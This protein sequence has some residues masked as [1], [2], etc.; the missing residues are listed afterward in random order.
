ML[1]LLCSL[2]LLA[3]QAAL[4]QHPQ[5]QCPQGQSDHYCQ[6]FTDSAAGL[7]LLA[8]PE[9]ATG[10]PNGT[11]N[12]NLTRQ[13]LGY[14][15]GRIGGKVLSID[16]DALKSFDSNDFFY[17]ALVRPFANSTTDR[18]TFFLTMQVAGQ[19][20][21]Y[22]AGFKVSTSIYSS[23]LELTTLQ[24]N[25][26]E[27]LQQAPA[28]IVLGAQDDIDGQWYLLRVERRQGNLKLFLNSQLMLTDDTIGNADIEQLGIWS[29]NRSFEL[30]YLRVGKSAIT[31][32]YINLQQA[33]NQPLTGYQYEQSAQIEWQVTGADDSDIELVNLTPQRVALRQQP[34]KFTVDYLQPGSA[35]VLLRSKSQPHIFKQLHISVLPALS[36][37][38]K[39]DQ[40]VLTDI[41]PAVNTTVPA[42]T[43]LRVN[44][45]RLFN[46]GGSG[47]VRIYQLLTDNNR[48]L[49]DEIRVKAETDTFGSISAN[50]LRSINRDMLWRDG[51][52]LVIKPH[53]HALQS[54]TRYQVVI[55]A[56]TVNFIDS[57]TQFAGIGIDANW[58]FSTTAVPVAR[59]VMQVAADGA[60]DFNTVQGALNF[61]MNA[62]DGAA[63]ETIRLAAGIYHEPLY[64]FATKNLTIEG[65]GAELS[66]IQFTNYD[67]LNS[68]L[69]RGVDL[70]AGHTAGG[71][72]L[73]LIEDVG[74]LTLKQLRFTNL[75]QRKQGVRNQAETVY[76]N[77]SGKLLAVNSHFISEQ[78]TLMLKGSSYF[79]R[80]LIAGNVDFIWGQNYLSLFEQNEIRSVGNSVKQ[81]DAE[82]VDGSYI[83]QA[84]TISADAPGFIFIN[85]R[86][87]S[88]PGPTGNRIRPGSTFLARSAGRP[89]YFD[90]V[91]LLNNQLGPHIAP[92][93]WAG[94]ANNEPVANPAI[95]N[96]NSGWREFG[97]ADFQGKPLDL[98]KRQ[99][100]IEL[101]AEQ[102]PYQD[103]K[104]VLQ[105][106]WPDFNPEWLY[107]KQSQ[108]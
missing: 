63:V 18:H 106:H 78:D 4:P 97:S 51:T 93:G 46:I 55:A 68:G 36:F 50:K 81:P 70:V 108:N 105:Q 17:E 45:K 88:Y 25:Q 61:V 42:D 94:P 53:S 76:F 15:A 100:G 44:L 107:S 40:A 1:L 52:T 83:L 16:T 26:V 31:T 102:L 84:R 8:T 24:N 66:H 33:E 35:S 43:L 101:S 38:A 59:P 21:H 37:P 14:K 13:T 11:L 27:V 87:T 12:L 80:C 49:V 10:Q 71:R 41:H 32:P 23:G 22:A 74:Q 69:G 7:S 99:Y 95:P 48:V 96:T 5:Y 75:H 29:F 103:S 86:F 2:P 60:A 39:T 77:S 30:D 28:P 90:Q 9:A 92:Q 98:S 47:A 34:G 72:S 91:L 58:S 3:Q 57:N 73:F 6:S 85:N 62:V 79:Y 82:F 64:L 20:L 89:A 54:D 104:A 56:D 65:A 19:Q 67:S